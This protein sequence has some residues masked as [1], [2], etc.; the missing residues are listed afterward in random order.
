MQSVLR[1]V[2]RGSA[3]ANAPVH[4]SVSAG[5]VA[6]ALCFGAAFASGCAMQQTSATPEVPEAVPYRIGPSDELIVRVLPDP[7]IEREVIVQ[8]DGTFA[9]DLIGEVDATSRTPAEVA[10]EIEER[11]AEYR[12]SPS[13]T[14]SLQ[15]AA[16]SSVTVIGEVKAP[17]MYPVERDLRITDVVARAGGETVYAAASRARLIRREGGDQATT[18]ISNLDRIHGGKLE[19]DYRVLRGDLI[20]VPPAATVEVGYHM[21][22]FLYPLEVLARILLAPFTA[23]LGPT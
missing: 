21:L 19:T 3:R 17:G 5:A 20:Y 6:L 23:V 1:S 9:F 11:I 4:R 22:R 18:Y 14:V 10:A 7:A 13:V 15:R 8:P 2:Q 12:V 16:S